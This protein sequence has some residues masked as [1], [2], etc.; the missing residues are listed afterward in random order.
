MW[1]VY[2]LQSMKD[3]QLYVGLTNDL[4]KRLQLHNQGKVFATKLRFPFEVIFYE[5]HH[6]KYDAVARE[7]F[8]K[9]GWGKN[10]VKR[11]LANYLKSKKLG[12]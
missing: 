5:A 2:I 4:K 3:D 1:Y 7:Q 10:W 12:G 11:T 9:S 8:L 6:N